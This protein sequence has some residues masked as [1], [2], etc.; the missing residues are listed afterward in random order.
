MHCVCFSK[1]N[2]NN[3]LSNL[4]TNSL[5]F[6]LFL[7]QDGDTALHLAARQDDREAALALLMCGADPTI[8]NKVRS[9]H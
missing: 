6:V 5:Q 8:R 4:E 9:S 7:A 2:L 3:F 1:A